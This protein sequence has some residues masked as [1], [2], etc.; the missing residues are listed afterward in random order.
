MQK[1]AKVLMTVLGHQ[2]SDKSEL[3]SPRQILAA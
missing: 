1:S 3:G 2:T